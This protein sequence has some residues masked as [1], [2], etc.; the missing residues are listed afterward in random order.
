MFYSEEKSKISETCACVTKD[1]IRSRSKAYKSCVG[2][3]D[4]G[5]GFLRVLEFRT[6]RDT[7]LIFH[8]DLHL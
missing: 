1:R 4:G 2:P 3:T 6:F 5:T 7:L 8:K